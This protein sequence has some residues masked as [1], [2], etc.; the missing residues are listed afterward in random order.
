[1]NTDSCGFLYLVATPI[2]NLADFSRRAI[3]VLNTVDRIAAEDTRHS[4][5]LLQHYAIDK[6]ML[7]LHEH[8]ERESA[9]GLVALLMQGESIAL[10]SDA[11]TP[12]VSD[13]GFR[14]VRLA[15]DK[16]IRVVPVPGASALIC[17]L[18]ASGL[19]TDRFVFEGFLPAK[20]NARRSQLE[21]L[22]HE[23]RT[24]IFYESSHRIA[25]SLQ[26]MAAVFGA[27]R[28]AVLARELT[29][30]FE[31]I[32]GDSLEKLAGQ[33]ASDKQ[34]QKG[35]MVILVKGEGAAAGHEVSQQAEQILAILIEELPIGQ[36]ARLAARITGI[37]KRALY[38]L[39]L[40]NRL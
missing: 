2:G 25:D 17:A 12:L 1:M 33:V 26:D 34:Q 23:T 4:R 8:N 20:R 6:P 5:K 3:D 36:A 13:P 30:Q 14:L 29:K 37:N 16:G 10:I 40:K 15:R 9:A 11:G 28:Q 24:L 7:A 18:S 27:D 21:S 31:T 38:D 19:P 32:L 22:K 39:A 35:E